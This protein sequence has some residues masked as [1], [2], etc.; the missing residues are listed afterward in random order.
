M[1]SLIVVGLGNPGAGYEH[2]RH[3]IGFLVVDELLSRWKKRLRPGK[4]EYL[5]ARADYAG[6]EVLLI[7]PL[8][9]MNNSGIAVRDILDR[10]GLGPQHLLVVC[11]DFALP[12][13]LLRIRS[14]GSDGGHNGLASIIMELQTDDFPR[15]RCGIQLEVMPPKDA[16]ADFV[17][18]VFG[19]AEREAVRAMITRAA[20]AV[21]ELAVSGIG[22]TM[23]IYNTN[24]Q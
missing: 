8:T 5:L 23:N 10:E 17:L 15:L 19:D 7:K 20:D 6:E 24:T 12:L 22:R 11:D 13:G 18:S 2:T 21:Q 16:M 14:R 4:G 1:G 3:N 9:Y